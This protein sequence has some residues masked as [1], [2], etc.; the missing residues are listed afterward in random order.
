MCCND[1]ILIRPES[2]LNKEIEDAETLT[3]VYGDCHTGKFLF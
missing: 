1:R 3:V 2:Y